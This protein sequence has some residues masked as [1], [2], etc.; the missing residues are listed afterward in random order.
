[1]NSKL[2]RFWRNDRRFEQDSRCKLNMS[3][4][5]V[6][7]K[8]LKLLNQINS[9][10]FS[11]GIVGCGG[12]NLT[13]DDIIS[14]KRATIVTENFSMSNLESR[15]NL[16]K[17]LSSMNG[18]ADGGIGSSSCSK[19]ACKK[20]VQQYERSSPA[21]M[22]SSTSNNLVV[23]NNGK[24]RKS[25]NPN[26][27]VGRVSDQTPSVVIATNNMQVYDRQAL[28]KRFTEDFYTLDKD[29]HFEFCVR[30]TQSP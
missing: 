10:G 7:K 21:I 23:Q 26:M 14:S 20:V 9:F 5:T 22:A 30:I 19:L 25:S 16:A 3:M 27:I 2:N 24:N 28:L 29:M 8:N 15:L 6:N 11:G 4:E 12:Q 17:S 1:M 18:S 13:S